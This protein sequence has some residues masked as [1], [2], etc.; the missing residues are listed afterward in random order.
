MMHSGKGQ[1]HYINPFFK[2]A[3]IESIECYPISVLNFQLE[4]DISQH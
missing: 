2:N 4:V 3:I 1:V